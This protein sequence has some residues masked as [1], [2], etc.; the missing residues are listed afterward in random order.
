[1]SCLIL[2]S[3]FHNDSSPKNKHWAKY[4]DGL[5][6]V[7]DINLMERQLIF[8]LNWDLK[9]T[10]EEMCQSLQSFL[11]PIKTDIIKQEKFQKY[12]QQKSRNKQMANAA[13]AVS[14]SATTT[15]S[16]YQ[17][18]VQVPV[19]VHLFLQQ[20]V[21][22]VVLQDLHQFPRSFITNAL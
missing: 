11:E 4:T 19:Q 22:L 5:F 6:N 1:M 9:V 18:Q 21:V 8:L 17:D 20:A 7:K 15:L 10:N 16:L 2:S 12:L 14:I 13:V 3:K